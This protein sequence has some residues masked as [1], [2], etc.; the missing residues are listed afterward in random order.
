MSLS[1]YIIFYILIS[2]KVRPLLTIVTDTHTHTHT[3][4]YTHTETEKHLALGEIMQICL[5]I[6]CFLHLFTLYFVHET[7]RLKCLL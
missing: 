3:Y 4:R 2:V 7:S 5:E 1:T 6:K